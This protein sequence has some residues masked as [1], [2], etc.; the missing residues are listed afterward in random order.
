MRVKGTE[1]KGEEGEETW[2]GRMPGKSG[3][4]RK[5]EKKKEGREIEG[6]EERG[7]G[8]GVETGGS[9][10]HSTAGTGPQAAGPRAGLTPCTLK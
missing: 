3:R 9:A 4:G 8:K 1:V 6:R 5:I 10:P 2:N 7:E